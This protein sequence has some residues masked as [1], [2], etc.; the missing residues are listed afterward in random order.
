MLK[1]ARPNGPARA[2]LIA[3]VVFVLATAVAF[4]HLPVASAA[5][6][7]YVGRSLVEGKTLY[8]DVWDDKLPSIYYL[9]ALWQLLFGARY[10]LHWVA[11]VAV[12]L[13]TLA[14]FAAFA[15]RAQVAHWAPATFALAVL[16]SLPPLRHFNYTEP[17]A[18]LFIMAALVAAQADA[19][20]ASGLLLTLA[21]TFWLPAVFQA[22][23]VAALCTESSARRR[24]LA[25]FIVSAAGCAVLVTRMFGTTAIAAGVREVYGWQAIRWSRGLLGAEARKLWDVLNATALLIPAVLALAVLHRPTNDRERFAVTWLVCALAGAAISLAFSQHEFLPAVAPLVFLIAAFS[26]GWQAPPVRRVV[27]AV[28][29]FVLS[30]RVP[31]MFATFR[32][33]AAQEMGEARESAAVGR[34]LDAALPRRSRILVYGYAGGIYLSARRDAAG[35]FPNHADTVATGPRERAEQAQYLA[36]ARSADAIVAS[37]HAVF[38]PS[39]NA[40]VHQDFVPAC[41]LRSAAFRVYLRRTLP[42]AAPCLA[43]RR[44]ALFDV[45]ALTN[46]GSDAGF[47]SD[48]SFSDEASPHGV[49]SSYRD[50]RCT[51]HRRDGRTRGCSGSRDDSRPGL[52]VSHAGSRRERA[53]AAPRHRRR[54]DDDVSGAR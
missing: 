19:P 1:D 30:M 18:M 22:F 23:A 46:G 43:A 12:L 41:R 37:R 10:V 52:L 13:A 32:N 25:A 2:W 50:D 47:R 27:T 14:L 54:D 3:A 48:A 20:I 42:A 35:R 21:A 49:S 26:E 40:L 45:P 15:R 51:D 44:D 39:L 16:L 5:L 38:F 24:F 36:G 7:E 53:R 17:Y 9:N 34:Q 29:V 11:E 31:A 4:Y 33:A 28:L 8:R 6:F